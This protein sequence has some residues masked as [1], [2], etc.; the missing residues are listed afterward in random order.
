MKPEELFREIDDFCQANTDEAIVKKYSRYFKDGYNGFGV[1]TEVFEL[2]LKSI[3]QD[4]GVDLNLLIKTA[5]LLIKTKRFEETSFAIHILKSFSRQFTKE[6]FKEVSKWFEIGIINWAHTDFICGDIMLI[7]FKMGIIS[8]QDLDK[9][10]IA[11][12]KFQR[13]AVP[14]SLIKELKKTSDYQHFLDFIDPMMMDPEREVHQGLGWFLREAWKR[15]PEQIEPF[16]F[17]W[18][19]KAPRLIFQYATEKMTPDQKQRYK[20]DK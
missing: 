5:P 9:W 14:V 19:N 10:R 15:Q 13:R 17:K 1:S 18:K 12:S 2:K 4:P 3:L 16:L 6:T 8:L 7:F 11:K 20:K